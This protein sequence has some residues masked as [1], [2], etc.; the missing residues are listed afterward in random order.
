MA[1]TTETETP[2]DPLDFSDVNLPIPSWSDSS[3]DE[4]DTGNVHAVCCH[5]ES[6]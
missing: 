2:F 4:E 3:S 1:Y 5:F 6:D